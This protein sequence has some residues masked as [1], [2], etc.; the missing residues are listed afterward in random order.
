MYVQHYAKLCKIKMTTM[1][2]ECNS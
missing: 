2:A 1:N